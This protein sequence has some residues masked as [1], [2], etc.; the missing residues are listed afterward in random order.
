MSKYYLGLFNLI[1]AAGWAYVLVLS[2][3]PLFAGQSPQA[4]WDKVGTVLIVVQSLAILEIFHS[5]FRLVN[6]PVLT[7]VMQVSS[8]LFLVW[9][10]TPNSALAQNHWSLYFMVL[11]WSLVE[12]PRY[13]FYAF[14]LFSMP[15]Y[16]L[17][18][19]RYSLFAILYPTGITGE[20]GQIWTAMKG[21]DGPFW[22]F[23]AFVLL[24]YVPGSPYMYFHMMVQ[25]AKA[26]NSFS[27]RLEK[28]Q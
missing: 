7:T 9:A 13:L 19:L 8:R 3:P 26:F 22:Y 18:W 11:S 25:R 5:L 1:A 6:S 14:N 27:I 17:F 21:Y 28:S 23:L 4:L 12:I 20:L 15:P 24:V 16:P 10:I 2:V